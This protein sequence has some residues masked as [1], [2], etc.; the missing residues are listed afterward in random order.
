[1]SEILDEF[2][3]GWAVHL[4]N[5]SDVSAQEE[6]QAA[7]SERDLACTCTRRTM[8]GQPAHDGLAM[9]FIGTVGAQRCA[10]IMRPI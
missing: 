2:S 8:D 6:G 9:A 1:M 7:I 5:K 3:K 4:S 10:A